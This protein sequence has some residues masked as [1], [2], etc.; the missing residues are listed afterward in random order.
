MRPPVR[1]KA[2]LS[3]AAKPCLGQDYQG[4]RRATR[5]V[6][7]RS[8]VQGCCPKVARPELV[9]SIRSQ[10]S[11]WDGA[12]GPGFDRSPRRDTL[13]AQIHSVRADGAAL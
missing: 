9:G 12:W 10:S 4:G 13:A 8:P 11:D 5:V 1:V 7:A 2:A 3:R 6:S